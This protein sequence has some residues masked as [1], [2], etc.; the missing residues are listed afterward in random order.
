MAEPKIQAVVNAQGLAAARMIPGIQ[1]WS[2]Q[3]AR[4]AAKPK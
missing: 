1:V 2:D 3:K 4:G